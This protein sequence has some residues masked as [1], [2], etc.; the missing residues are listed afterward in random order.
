MSGRLDG[1]VAVLVGAARGIGEA[2]A[3]VFHEEGAKLVIADLARRWRSAWIAPA[4]R[5]FCAQT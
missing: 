4:T 2:I 1:K 5:S 3:E